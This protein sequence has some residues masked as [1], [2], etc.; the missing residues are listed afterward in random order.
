MI[1]SITSWDRPW[2]DDTLYSEPACYPDARDSGT[3]DTIRADENATDVSVVSF[4]APVFRCLAL[5]V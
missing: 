4:T 1:C 5:K 2:A 3:L